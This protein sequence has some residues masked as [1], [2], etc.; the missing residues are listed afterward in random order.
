MAIVPLRNE[1]TINRAGGV[2]DWGNPRPAETFTLSC[3]VD[4]GSKLTVSKTGGLNNAETTVAEAKILFDKLAD[5]R[6]S[7]SV[8]F[9]NELGVEITRKPMSI[10]VKRMINGKP[11]ST[12][13]LV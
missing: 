4:E 11:I 8:T 3:R 2:D 10:N 5:I 9:K 1:V 12:E 6:Y 7:D 13:V